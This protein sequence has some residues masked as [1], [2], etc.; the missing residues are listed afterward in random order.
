[1]LKSVLDKKAPEPKTLEEA[2]SV[3]NVLWQMVRELSARVEE[4]EDQLAQDSGNSSRPPS[5]D[6]PRQRAERKKKKRTGRM[7]S[8]R[9]ATRTPETST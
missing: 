8:R 7:Q 1:M 9:C 2:Q 5:Q 4:L 3:I 6:S